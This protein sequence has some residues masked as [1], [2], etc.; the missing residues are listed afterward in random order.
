MPELQEFCEKYR[1][2]LVECDLRWG[3]PKNTTSDDTISICLE[4]ID[5][6]IQE[7]GGQPFFLNMLG[8][9]YVQGS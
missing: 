6:C 5:R 1:I 3:V 8:E 2:H 7:T 9:R 4:E